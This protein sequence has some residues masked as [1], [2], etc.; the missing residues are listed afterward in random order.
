MNRSR[1]LVNV[2]GMCLVI[3]A[4]QPEVKAATPAG[5]RGGPRGGAPANGVD[6]LAPAAQN[7]QGPPQFRGAAAANGQTAWWTDT[8]LM[9][10]LGL[11]DLQKARIE[12]SF[13]AYR[14]SLASAKETL[15]KEEAQLS[16]L[17]DADSVDRSAVTL[18]VNRVIQ[19]RS[20][21]ERVNA[22]MT[23]EMREQLTRAQWTQLQQPN[24][25]RGGRGGGLGA[26]DARGGRAGGFGPPD[27]DSFAAKYAADK[28]V[29]LEGTVTEFRFQD[30]HSFIV[31]NVVGT[32][33]KITSWTGELPPRTLLEQQG[34]SRSSLKLGERVVVEGAQAHDPSLN[35]VSVRVVRK[36]Q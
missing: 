9:A 30:P 3:A 26:G 16:K 18:Q 34:W 20:E 7:A 12:S 32:D 11:T 28:P 5:Q 17:L 23:L 27:S 15:E 13:Q 4:A 36:L 10:R 24:G 22:A 6:L 31:F 8:A 21:M 2:I 1:M 14:Q 33:G 25:G 35:A 29:T 19:A